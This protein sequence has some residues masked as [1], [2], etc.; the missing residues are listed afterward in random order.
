MET[1]INGLIDM[2]KDLLD[3][4]PGGRD[5]SIY[6]DVSK[7]LE[8]CGEVAETLNKSKKTDQDLAEELSDVMLVCAIIA[9]KKGIDLNQANIDKH[10]KRVT[11]VLNRFHDGLY[12]AGLS[13][14]IKI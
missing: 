6:F 4:T 8:E 2:A 9:H 11:K 7:L 1:T 12:P 14:R 3:L 10:A 13:P 5:R